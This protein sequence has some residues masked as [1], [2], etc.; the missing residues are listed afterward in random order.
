MGR[1]I[2]RF[3]AWIRSW[4]LIWAIV[5]GVAS[6]FIYVNIHWLDGTHSFMLHALE[7]V[8]PLLIFAMLF[9]TFCRVNPK[10][11][12]LCKW[13]WWLLGFQCFMFLAFGVIAISLPIH[14]GLRV[15]AEG[16]MICFICPVATAGAVVTRKLGG[17]AS[18]ITTYTIL[19]NLVAAILIPVVVPWVHSEHSMSTWNASL[20][21]LGKV[22]PLL[23]FPLMLAFLVRQLSPKLHFHISRQ[24]NLSFYLWVV[25]LFIAMAVTT[26]F[27]MHTSVSLS[28]ELGLVAVAGISCVLQFAVGWKIGAKYGDRITAGQSLGQKNTVL[29]IWIGYTF[30][31]P[32]TSLA[33]GF[34][35]IFHNVINSR[36]LY[37]H[38]HL[39]K[40]GGK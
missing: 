38:A 1:F 14:S 29:A 12:R 16:A 13:H 2:G 6:Y 8:Q 23:L 34:Y 32:V 3:A 31:T 35:S 36:Q 15:V 7:I 26:R 11:L 17:N 28:V 27:I 9:V 37:H 10:H 20:L 21:I 33:G 40:N 19:I 4:V 5:C 24:Q 22:F 39:K 18:H 25:A 30:F